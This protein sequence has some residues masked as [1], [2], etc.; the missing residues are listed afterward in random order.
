MNV[1]EEIGMAATLEQC[2]EE[3]VELAHACLKMARILRGENPTPVNEETAIKRINEESADVMVCINAIVESGLLSY[4]AIDS[5]VMIKTDRWV[6]R[7]K[8]NNNEKGE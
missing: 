5:E 3:C 7:I 8:E 4:E 2:A 6:N 1:V